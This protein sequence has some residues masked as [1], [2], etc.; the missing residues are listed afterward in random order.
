MRGKMDWLLNPYYFVGLLGVVMVC[1]AMWKASN[2]ETNDAKDV[3]AGVTKMQASI[4]EKS[5][6]EKVIADQLIVIAEQLS[7]INIEKLPNMEGFIKDA[8]NKAISYTEKVDKEVALVKE[9]VSNLQKKA[10]DKSPM[11]VRVVQPVEIVYTRKEVRPVGTKGVETLI[12][13]A[14]IPPK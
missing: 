8:H 13:K 10:R 5:T 1:W 4:N 6:Q 12:Q 9:Q 3:L 14:N 2:V 7:K 11:D